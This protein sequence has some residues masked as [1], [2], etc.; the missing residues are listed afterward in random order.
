[1]AL[2]R[3]L[4]VNNQAGTLGAALTG[5]GITF[6][7]VPDF[8]TLI[9][10]AYVPISV[11]YGTSSFEVVYL[12]TFVAGA[13]T[14]VV[15]R[16]REGTVETDHDDGA[17]WAHAYTVA[18]FPDV[19][20]YWVD[21]V[22]GAKIDGQVVQDGVMTAS[23]AVLACTTSTPFQAS[24]VGKEISVA[25][26]AA[27][28]AVLCTTILG[29]TN[30]GH[31]TLATAATDATSGAEVY[32]GTDDTAAWR[33]AWSDIDASPY[34][35]IARSS[36]PGIS[37]LNS[38]QVDHP[39][40]GNPGI[41]NLPYVN[42]GEQYWIGKLF[43]IWGPTPPGMPF[44]VAA[45]GENPGSSL[46]LMANSAD[47]QAGGSGGNVINAGAGGTTFSCILASFRNL[48]VRVPA[49]SGYSAFNLGS[50]A[51]CE[52]NDV[53]SDVAC[54]TDQPMMTEPASGS[55]GFISPI[56]DNGAYTV[57]DRCWAIGYGWGFYVNEHFEGDHLVAGWCRTSYVIGA[58]FHG[59]HIGRCGSYH[60]GVHL[61]TNMVS[62][63]ETIQ[64]VIDEFDIE[65]APSGSAS[66]AMTSEHFSDPSNQIYGSIGV[67]DVQG[68]VG[69]VTT[70]PKTS[71]CVHLAIKV[72]GYAGWFTPG[73][74]GQSWS[75]VNG[76][77]DEGSG[78]VTRFCKHADGLVELQIASTC[79]GESWTAFTLPPGFRPG[80]GIDF[81]IWRGFTNGVGL[82]EITTA[83]VVQLISNDNA[84]MSGNF[85]AVVCF[86]AEN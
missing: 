14:G 47:A 69:Q 48:I 62:S 13:T 50:A 76:W 36:V 58:G 66:W 41:L 71:G 72:I 3:R 75:Y 54:G 35:G 29:F 28:G 26:A 46:I 4:R 8:P 55:V 68:D 27:G 39:L 32:W 45:Q 17:N 7:S 82:G 25:G 61:G 18:D 10:N 1:V 56:V 2:G 16:G 42:P 40:G 77:S 51:Q 78:Y 23:S 49:G 31:V 15:L 70:Y 85:A 44:T 67:V 30:S 19:P 63:P 84:T 33:A 60:S 64:L 79:G 6:E 37:F 65:D 83:G 43:G 21:L 11:D 24:D 53:G 52:L 59:A 81:P 74:S 34:G 86:T 38:A 22:Y 80:Q 73:T 20:F 12:T 5:T 9:D 57:L